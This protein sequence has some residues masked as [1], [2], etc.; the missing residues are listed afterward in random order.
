MKG[1][2]KINSFLLGSLLLLLGC[3]DDKGSYNYHDIN[4]INIELPATVN[5]RLSKEEAVPV[6]IEPKLSQTISFEIL[7]G[8]GSKKEYRIKRMGGMRTGK[9]VSIGVSTDRRG[10][11][12]DTFDR[13]GS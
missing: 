3:Y 13:Y 10:I 11:T 5:V 12:D 4:E 9:N 8:K 1:F 2:V 7:M 6:S